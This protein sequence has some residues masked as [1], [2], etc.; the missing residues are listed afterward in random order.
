M[1]ILAGVLLLRERVNAR[2]AAGA[3]LAILGLIIFRYSTPE[4][5]AAY[6]VR[7]VWLF[8]VSLILI[9]LLSVLQK[10]FFRR[11]YYQP[12]SMV[13][14]RNAVIALSMFIIALTQSAFRAAQGIEWFYLIVGGFAGPF[15]N[16]F[17]MLRAIKHLPVATVSLVRTLSALT[18]LIASAFIYRQLP[19]VNEIIGAVII[20]AA[21]SYAV[22]A[23]YGVPWR[24]GKSI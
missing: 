17:F 18:L 22:I 6:D 1:N 24:R 12:E 2:F 13:P 16:F 10:V 3:A 7:G 5:E 15:M 9:A 14:L 21:A 8:L 23:L 19:R 20:F 11:G 4:T